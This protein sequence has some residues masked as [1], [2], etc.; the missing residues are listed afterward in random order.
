MSADEEGRTVSKPAAKL[1][2][3][4]PAVLYLRRSTDR[5]EASIVDQRSHLVRYAAEQGFEIL[6]E[7]IDDGISGTSANARGAFQRMIA[8]AQGNARF[9]FILTYDIKRFSRGDI[10]E[11]GHYRHLLKERGVDVIYATENFGDDFTSELI[12]PMRQWQARQESVDLSK[13]TARGQMSS[14]LAGSY[15]GSTPPW[16]FD[17]LYSN[18]RGEP[19]HIVRYLPS[20]EKDVLD[21]DGIFRMRV[22]FGERPPRMDNDSVR[23]VL[24]LP[25]RV[26]TIRNIFQWYVHEGDRKSVV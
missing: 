17:Y 22:P 21:P 20:G 15:F 19:F 10:D 7:F 3:G 1:S 24:S 26:E 12:R 2:A 14:I 18:S 16:G 13:L 8:E 23:L 11:A 25:E 5:Q 6:D 9:R 4:K